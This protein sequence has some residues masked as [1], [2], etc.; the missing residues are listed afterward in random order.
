MEMHCG[1][2]VIVMKV[3]DIRLKV[4]PSKIAN[5]FVRK[6]HYSGRVTMSSNLHFG[7]F[8][9]KLLHGVMSF[10]SP[11]DKRKVIGL[12]EG[13]K[14]NEMLELN[15][16]AFDDILPP[17][18]E[19]RCLSIA[20]K[21][22]KKYAPHIKWILSFADGTQCGDG[23]IYRASGFVLTNINKN[24]TI[25]YSGNLKRI[26]AKHGQQSKKHGKIKLL[27]GY[28]LRYIKFIKVEERKNLT[29][30]EIPYSRIKE[31]GIGMYKGERLCLVGEKKSQ[32]AIQQEVRGV[33]PTTRLQLNA[34]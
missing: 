6:H 24:K 12:V 9:N 33:I 15:R 21:L 4:I 28:Q 19:S 18:S 22:I 13:T 31:M 14:W 5:N 3:K 34:N 2:Y 30:P 27:Q 10:G 26:V 16:M 17:N 32:S 7:A 8:D 20:F 29:V 23:T 11:L 1:G 25:G